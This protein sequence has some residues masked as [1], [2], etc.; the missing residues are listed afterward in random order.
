MGGDAINKIKHI[1]ADI[2]LLGI[3][4]I[5]RQHGITDN[6]WDIV[7]MKKA[8]IESS[9]QTVVMSISE[10]LN[11]TQRIRVC[12]FEEIDV[13]VTELDPSHALLDPFRQQ[14]TIVL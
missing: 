9:S 11:T 8:M 1:K 5:D 10:K 2:C 7:Q 6:D 13:L 3:N 14:G 4:A 12:G